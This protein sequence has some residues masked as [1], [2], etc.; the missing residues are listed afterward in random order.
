MKLLTILMIV[1]MLACVLIIY[2]A[3]R[4]ILLCR[5]FDKEFEKANLPTNI[6][7]G[8][9]PEEAVQKEFGSYAVAQ[10]IADADITAR[11]QYPYSKS[12]SSFIDILTQIDKLIAEEIRVNAD[13]PIQDEI[14]TKEMLKMRNIIRV[15][16][17]LTGMS[18]IAQVGKDG[19]ERRISSYF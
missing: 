10:K 2:A 16:Q 13:P 11:I 12:E 4:V 6:Y 1:W 17:P 5:R 7:N 18:Y 3:I 14:I 15:Y 8:D 19:K 9:S